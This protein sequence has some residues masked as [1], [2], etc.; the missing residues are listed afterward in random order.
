MIYRGYLIEKDDT[1]D[2]YFPWVVVAPKDAPRGAGVI[3]W[4][5]TRKDAKG[6]VDREIETVE[7]RS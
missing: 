4:A 2:R 3:G 1:G 7:A 6:L 5:H